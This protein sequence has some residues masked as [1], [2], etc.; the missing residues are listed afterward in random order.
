ME[1][2]RWLLSEKSDGIWRPTNV[3]QGTTNVK[4]GTNPNSLIGR[5][6]NVA[7]HGLTYGTRDLVRDR[8]YQNSEPP[9]PEGQVDVK[10]IYQKV[11][12]ALAGNT[13]QQQ[14]QQQQ[15]QQSTAQW[16]KE[17]SLRNGLADLVN[18]SIQSG[19]NQQAAMK[20]D[21]EA[22]VDDLAK[23]NGNYTK[24]HIYNMK[25]NG[26]QTFLRGKPT[27]NGTTL[28]YQLVIPRPQ[29]IAI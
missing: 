29:G 25:S 5:A 13:P 20:K 21:F 7:V 27:L 15:Q 22:L 19:G 10:G 16:D 23:K 26:V 9:R 14:Q 2:K 17:A 18:R 4:Q 12:D 28:N 3:K 11:K 1:F 24:A 8:M 6:M